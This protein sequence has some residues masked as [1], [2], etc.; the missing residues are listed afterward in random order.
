MA[1]AL[2]VQFAARTMLIA[3]SR[4]AIHAGT[5]FG[6]RPLHSSL[7]PSRK[8]HVRSEDRRWAAIAM[9][10]NFYSGAVA[11]SKSSAPCK[12]RLNIARILIGSRW[13][14]RRSWDALRCSAVLDSRTKRWPACYSAR[15][16]SWRPP[17]WPLCCKRWTCGRAGCEN[18]W[19]CLQPIRPKS[20]QLR[21]ARRQAHQSLRRMRDHECQSGGRCIIQTSDPRASVKEKRAEPRAPLNHQTI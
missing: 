11:P 5:S 8:R 9:R 19:L 4:G 6:Q 14:F 10:A 16:T 15:L 12:R 21:F 2:S 13:V 17:N 3:L 20:G 7:T 1:R 18:R